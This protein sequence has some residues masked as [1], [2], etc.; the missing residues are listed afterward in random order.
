MAAL[1]QRGRIAVGSAQWILEEK[2]AAVQFVKEEA[3][4]FAFAVRNEME[5]LN[6][7]MSDVFNRSQL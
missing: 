3:D 2:S 7:H 4:E 6:E 5:W 1:Q